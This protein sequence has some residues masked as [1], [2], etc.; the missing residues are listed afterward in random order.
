MSS[1]RI[2]LTNDDGIDA[3]GLDV[4]RRI[5]AKI[6][7]DIWVVA[8]T[9]NQ[10]G[11]GHRFT[12]G[13]ELTLEQRSEREFAVNGTPADCVVAGATHV[14]GG[15]GPDLVLSGVNNGQ[16]LGDIIHCSG[17]LAGAR[18]GALHGAIGIALSQGVDYEA[19][20]TVSWSSAETHGAHVVRALMRQ[21]Q[22]RNTY[23]NVNFPFCPANA[24]TGISVVPHQRFAQAAFRYYQSDNEG[25][26]FVTI[27]EQPGPIEPG[28][29]F[30]SLL[31]TDSIVVTP[32]RL[33]HT[34]ND[35][36]SRL[37]GSLNLEQAR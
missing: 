3:P 9:G 27:P 12:L 24:V 16:N 28:K 22:G 32:L 30:H 14:M 4:L 33:D 19:Q 6:S 37:S 20:V 13:R 10:S 34:D 25:C 31:K 26:F 1:P 7:D 15:E 23:F 29:D 21:A 36:V 18:E 35:E 8:P 2:L 5:A 17:T 11:A